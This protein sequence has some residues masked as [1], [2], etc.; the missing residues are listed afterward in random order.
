[1]PTTRTSFKPGHKGIGG[2]PR[3]SKTGSTKISRD[4]KTQAINL[5]NQIDSLIA[6]LLSKASVLGLLQLTTIA[7]IVRRRQSAYI[8]RARH[9][10]RVVKTGGRETRFPGVTLITRT[11][12]PENIPENV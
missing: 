5:G 6:H 3:G 12:H 11:R 4:A 7:E 2:R 1:M 8:E 10:R 9:R